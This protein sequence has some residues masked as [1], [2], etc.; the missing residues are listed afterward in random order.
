MPFTP[1]LMLTP[2]RILAPDSVRLRL[3]EKHLGRPI[4]ITGGS[5]GGKTKLLELLCR[6]LASQRVGFTY[7]DP[8]GDGAE[9]VL[10]CLSATEADPARI[11]Y[12]K[13][14]AE[15]AIR[16]DPFAHV[17]PG[18]SRIKYA[19]WLKATAD[20]VV[21]ACLRNFSVSD[22]EMMA[23][24]Q[25]WLR[26]IF[27]CCGIDV[28]GRHVGIGRALLF[29][30]PQREE[31]REIWDRIGPHVQKVDPDTFFEMEELRATSDQNRLK[32]IESSRNCIHR[33]LRLNVVKSVFG[34][35]APT[36]LSPR[37]I[38]LGSEIQLCDLRQT[39][40]I[41]RPQMNV[42]GGIIA[43]LMMGQAQTLAEELPFDQRV[44]HFLIIDEAENFVGEDIRMGF[45]ELRKY[46]MPLCLA[47]QDI[48]CLLKGDLDLISKAFGNAG[49][50]ISFCQQ[51]VESIEY[52]GKTF[53]YGSLDFTPLLIHEVLPDGY[54]KVITHGVQLGANR[55]HTESSSASETK[56]HTESQA[57]QTGKSIQHS[58]AQ[59]LSESRSKGKSYT[60][61]EGWNESHTDGSSDTTGAGTSSATTSGDTHGVTRAAAKTTRNGKVAN[62]SAAV[63]ETRARQQSTTGGQSAFQ[64]G[65][66]SHSDTQ[67]ISGSVSRGQQ[68]SNTHGKTD[69]KGQTT[70]ESSA[71]SQGT[72]DARGQGTTQGQADAS[73]TSIGV[74]AN[75][76]YLA[77]HK[78]TQ[79]P[80][81]KQAVSVQ[82][83]IAKVMNTLASLPDRRVLVKCK[84]LG[85]PFLLDVHAVIDPYVEKQLVRTQ[86]YKEWEY[87]LLLEKINAAHAYYFV[88]EQ[89]EPGSDTETGNAADARR[90]NLEAPAGKKKPF[91]D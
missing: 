51:D 40:T 67:G 74:S 63:A 43:N 48:N 33:I 13:P 34:T 57:T 56:T 84:G 22:Q 9:T 75:E 16:I 71:E 30:K 47:F 21:S 55:T 61:M 86:S 28:D 3:E 35:H 27:F 1:P 12:I 90:V 23:R 87:R 50:L 82:D 24:L 19:D 62:E 89:I 52:L 53:A 60:E 8:H 76:T 81:G 65:S 70:G 54:E 64:S 20:R 80:S 88:P 38:I 2:G 39:D 25:S 32:L 6:Q 7:L 15:Q 14:R 45:A 44:P 58:V 17:P 68:R 85:F 31:F 83:Q 36:S 10:R 11:H 29:T 37:Q 46:R 69:T 49:L 5:G 18:L 59:A 42:L 91:L 66:T 78:I 72:A 41:S 4:V 79:L 77:K 26:V 73:G